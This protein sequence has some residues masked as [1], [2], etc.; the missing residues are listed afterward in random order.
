MVDRFG[1]RSEYTDL[2][3]EEPGLGSE[4]PSG[5]DEEPTCEGASAETAWIDTI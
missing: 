3:P 1:R 2:D 4:E 5:C